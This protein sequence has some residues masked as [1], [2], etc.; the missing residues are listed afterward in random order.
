MLPELQKL[1]NAL[2]IRT[3]FSSQWCEDILPT[4]MCF[5]K[6]PKTHTQN[7]TKPKQ[8]KQSKTKKHPKI[9]H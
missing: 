9:T 4:G 2:S 8:P 7:Q 1:K 6:K 5:K 3:E